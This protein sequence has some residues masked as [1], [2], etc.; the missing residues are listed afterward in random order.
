[1]RRMFAMFALMLV[2]AVLAAGDSPPQAVQL[3]QRASQVQN[4]ETPGSQAFRLSISF[5]ASLRGGGQTGGTYL[6]VWKAPQKWREEIHM[7]GFNQLTVGGDGRHWTAQNLGIEPDSVR[8]LKTLA[9]VFAFTPKPIEQPKRVR[10]RSWQGKTLTCIDWQAPQWNSKG[11]SCFDAA[12]VLVREDARDSRR[13]YSDYTAFGQK[14]YP[15][16]LRIEEEGSR[17]EARVEQLAPFADVNDAWFMP[18]PNSEE[19]PTCDV[20]EVPPKATSTPDPGFPGRCTGPSASMTV[21]QVVVGADGRPSQV[22]VATS[23]GDA[24]DKAAVEA[25]QTWR[26][27]PATCGSTPVK[28]QIR[29]EVNFRCGL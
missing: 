14:M 6:L 28:S 27:R 21:L 17:L 23:A 8:L 10:D 25:V 26:F 11:E 24:F 12:G 20:G 18:P 2:S 1:M 5:R 13:E 4:L 16:A 3:L 15:R 7:P 22:L 19:W 29:V 9:E